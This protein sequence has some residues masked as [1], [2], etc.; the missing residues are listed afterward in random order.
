MDHIASLWDMVKDVKA[1]SAS[2][3]Y[4]A[5]YLQPTVLKSVSPAAFN[6]EKNIFYHSHSSPSLEWL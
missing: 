1:Y 3:V 6:H 5:Q 4:V 2:A